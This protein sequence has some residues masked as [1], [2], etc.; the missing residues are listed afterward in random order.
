MMASV[1]EPVCDG[2]HKMVDY[3]LSVPD[4]TVWRRLTGRV[5]IG[6]G[7]LEISGAAPDRELATDQA[8][9]T[10]GRTPLLMGTRVARLMLTRS[11][12]GGKPMRMRRRDF[13]TGIAGSAAAWPLAARAQQA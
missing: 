5:P 10:L 3:R 12:V 11:C 8:R 13:I 2:H 6:T 1:G 4:W 7:S 9:R